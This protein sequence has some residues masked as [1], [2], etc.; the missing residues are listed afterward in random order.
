MKDISNIV[1]MKR[2]VTS[3]YL[4]R[5]RARKA[6]VSAPINAFSFLATEQLCGY[7]NAYMNTY[8]LFDFSSSLSLVKCDE[9]FSPSTA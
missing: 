3:F 8:M 2:A 4:G 1:N 7:M 5:I 9:G 6:S